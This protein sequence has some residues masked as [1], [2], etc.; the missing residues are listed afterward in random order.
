VKGETRVA[1]KKVISRNVIAILEGEGPKA[2]ETIVIG[3]HYDHLGFPASD[4]RRPRPENIYNGADDNASG[5]AVVLEVARRLAAREKKLPRRV[6]FIAFA[7][8]E[9]GLRGSQHYVSHSPVPLEKTVAMLNLD[10]VGRLRENT[11]YITGTGTAK[12]FTAWLDRANESQDFDLAGSPSR[13]GMSD[14]SP[15]HN[16][17]I[18]AVHF[19]TGIHS[20]FHST[21][22]DFEKINVPGMRRVAGL[23]ADMVVQIAEAEQPPCFEREQKKKVATP[24]PAPKTQGFRIRSVIKGSLAEKAGVL[25]D[26]VVLRIG[27][28]KIGGLRDFIAALRKHKPGEKVECVVRRGDKE[29]TLTMTFEKP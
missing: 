29:V 14:H 20:D 25:K 26:D 13:Y 18:P 19:I 23:V 16:K 7:A 10:M 27:D 24:K 1:R 15:F 11:L 3:A 2:E 12:E 17:E 6:L 5:V 8:E 22:D 9:R 4:G 28:D 21:T